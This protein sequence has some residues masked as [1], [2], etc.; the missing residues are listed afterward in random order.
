MSYR[1]RESY[2]DTSPGKPTNR[3]KMFSKQEFTTSYTKVMPRGTTR[4]NNTEGEPDGTPSPGFPLT[5]SY[6][7][8][9]KLLPKPPYDP[10][11][12]PWHHDPAKP[13]PDFATPPPP[14]SPYPPEWRKPLLPDDWGIIKFDV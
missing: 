11:G 1:N 2:T 5:P 12:R 7:Q 14:Q 3:Q 4:S 9:R 10:T 6:E 13:R 8:P